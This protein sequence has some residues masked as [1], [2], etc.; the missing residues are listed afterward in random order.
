MQTWNLYFN[1]LTVCVEGGQGEEIDLLIPSF[2]WQ[3]R[4]MTFIKEMKIA[5]TELTDENSPQ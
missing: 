5:K 1:T 2:T 4:M 3:S